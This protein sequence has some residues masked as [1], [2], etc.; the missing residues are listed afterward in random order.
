M[1]GT[2]TYIH[3][4]YTCM[5]ACTRVHTHTHT[6][7]IYKHKKMNTFLKIIFRLCIKSTQ[8][9]NEFSVQT[10]VPFTPYQHVLNTILAIL[11][12]FD[13]PS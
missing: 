8:N 3:T 10:W 13:N 5:H 1:Y 7:K 6:G 4:F 12:I 9:I 11:G 2:P